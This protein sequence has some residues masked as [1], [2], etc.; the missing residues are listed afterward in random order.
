MRKGQTYSTD[1]PIDKILHIIRA[2]STNLNVDFPEYEN[3]DAITKEYGKTRGCV[4]SRILRAMPKKVEWRIWQENGT[5]YIYCNPILG[6][7]YYSVLVILISSFAILYLLG[8][9]LNMADYSQ[10]TS[11]QNIHGL[12]YILGSIMLLP[13]LAKLLFACG[14]DRIKEIFSQLRLKAIESGTHLSE[15]QSVPLGYAIHMFTFLAIVI[16][17]VF[18]PIIQ[19]P[20]PFAMTGSEVTFIFVIISLLIGLVIAAFGLS[21]KGNGIS[22]RILPALGGI[23][24]CLAVLLILLAQFPWYITANSVDS[25][26]LD[27]I[28]EVRIENIEIQ[29]FSTKQLSASS[30]IFKDAMEL[31]LAITIIVSVGI[32]LVGIWFLYNGV[33]TSRRT[34]EYLYQ[35]KRCKDI[36][37]SK[38][39]LSGGKA[40]LKMRI[41]ICFLWIVYSIAL[42]MAVSLLSSSSS[43]V[44]E[45][46]IFGVSNTIPDQLNI[47]VYMIAAAFSID[48]SNPWIVVPII[49]L[50]SMYIIACWTFVLSPLIIFLVKIHSQY[51]INQENSASHEIQRINHCLEELYSIGNYSGLKPIV[52]FRNN[53]MPFVGVKRSGLIRKQNNLYVSSSCLKHLKDKELMAVFA[54]EL[55]H[56]TLSHTFNDF[57]LRLLGR[58]TLVGDGL[59]R[60]LQDSVNN[61]VKADKHAVKVYHISP[62]VLK[63]SILIL[64]NISNIQKYKKSSLR[65]D[66]LQSINEKYDIE[67]LRNA[68]KSFKWYSRLKIAWE[69]Y[70]SQY[71]GVG[72]SGYWHPSI[73]V[74]IQSLERDNS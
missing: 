59:V 40:L 51:N 1:L 52:I 69:I 53:D 34:L 30:I 21:S 47:T 33:L 5:S 58:I 45:S 17:V 39:A 25:N 14:Q 63:R 32:F 28:E 60:I 61:E 16:G 15:S 49:G 67:V 54:H 19:S 48:P 43:T 73:A 20:F 26:F 10:G 65:D 64:Y 56:L 66:T 8:W 37:W 38:E 62:N 4:Y 35:L 42:L 11:I 7:A 72:Y 24:T 70:I 2:E 18:I 68:L 12:L 22:V 9:E 36:D 74:R 29:Q 71:L 27:R 6:L 46:L 57:Y 23:N 50:W 13:I 31:W 3:Y 55:A 41:N 44:F